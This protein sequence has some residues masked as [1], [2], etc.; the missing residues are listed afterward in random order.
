MHST[1]GASALRRKAYETAEI[2][3]E[4][5]GRSVE[6]DHPS[7]SRRGRTFLDAASQAAR[8]ALDDENRKRSRHLPRARHFHTERLEELLGDFVEEA[9]Q[10]H[11]WFSNIVRGRG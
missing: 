7:L 9:L 2:A 5:D 6:R 10:A 11:V 1:D 8:A 3:T 4:R